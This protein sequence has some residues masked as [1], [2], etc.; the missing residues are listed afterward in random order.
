MLIP[1]NKIDDVR[2][3]V[4]IVD[5]IGGVVRLKKAGQN[6][7]GLCPFHQEKTP[8]FSVHPGKQIYKCFGCGEGGNVF[9]FLM[10]DQNL[11]FYDSVRQVAAKAGI[12]LPQ[13]R[14]DTQNKK[15][16]EKLYAVNEFA[17]DWY[18][19]NLLNSHQ[20]QKPLSYL[21]KR[22]FK[23]ETINAFGLGYAQDA[24]E[25]LVKAAENSAYDGL[26]LV[27]AGLALKKSTQNTPYD[28]FRNR[29]VFPIKNEFGRI[30]GF[31]ARKFDDHTQQDKDSPK[32]INS[33][34]TPVYHK[35]KLL[36]GLYQNK[37]TIRK[38]DLVIIV[39][40]Y[41]D[42]MALHEFGI[43]LGVATLGTA[44]S[45]RQAQ[46]INRY[47]KNVVLLYDADEPG[48]KAALRGAEILLQANLEVSV[49]NL[50][51]GADPDSFLREN[52]K[53]IFM[54]AVEN[55]KSIVDFYVSGF[56]DTEKLISYN[57][58]TE[59]IRNIIEL[60]NSVSDRLKREV[61]LQEIGEKLNTDMKSIFKEFY[62]KKRAIARFRG[63]KEP[64]T[65]VT[66]DALS[67]ID[68]LEQEF[69]SIV[70]NS[71]GLASVLMNSISDEDIHSPEILKILD[72]IKRLISENRN[73]E[74]A[75]IVSASDDLNL[76]KIIIDLAF[77]PNE[78]PQ[79]NEDESLERLQSVSDG[80]I[81]KF[82]K[83]KIEN[84]LGRLQEQIKKT[85]SKGGDTI[86]LISQYH[87]LLQQKN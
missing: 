29:I 72:F 32:Y 70:I 51:S 42:V 4:N 16:Y 27:E 64:K 87:D 85:E 45:L 62:N 77:D 48:I 75:D 7:M 84:D 43:G 19:N 74:P 71:P 5:V 15:Q 24:W 46:L 54:E 23:E 36:Y 57:A 41:T 52:S 80:L 6:F 39:E 68:P 26:S 8:S 25:G 28:R 59:R 56:D 20:G 78:F 12:Q 9:T 22:G 34:E 69:G 61:M 49:V 40:G 86:P 65:P 11:T 82:K 81:K 55:S 66:R 63:N 76:Q 58:K 17:A 2:N 14:E 35:S 21:T 1:E 50:G 37:D 83:R 38:Q 67:G 60:V 73:Y 44:L 13:F 3:S 33:P 30:V 79:Q 31:G 47:T 18:R 53:E 10:K